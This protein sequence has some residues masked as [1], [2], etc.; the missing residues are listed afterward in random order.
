MIFV[1]SDIHGYSYEKYMSLLEKAEFRKTDFLYVLGDVIDRGDD[2][3]TILRWMIN[4]PN[5]ELILGNHEAMMLLCEYIFEEINKET[6]ASLNQEKMSLLNTWQFNGAVPTLK[7]LTSLNKEEREGILEF[8]HEAPLYDAITVNGKDYLFTH[9]GLGHF[10]VNK[11]ISQYAPDD[12]LW[13]RPRI[14]DRYFDDVTVIFGH[15]PT[16]KYGKQF[17]G[18][19]IKTDTW[20]NI[21]TGAGC[22]YHPMLLCLDTM[23]EFYPAKMEIG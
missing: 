8:L 15:T 1:T 9:S 17:A 11:K 7:S 12:L 2:G 22:G 6:I 18:R 20:I 21:D 5:V 19:M 4:Q 13:N 16:V 23:Q 10:D 14:N 3:V